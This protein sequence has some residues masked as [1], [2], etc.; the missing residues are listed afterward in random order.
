MI[1]L[2]LTRLNHSITRLHIHRLAKGVQK[3]P[4]HNIQLA[5]T[6]SEV[7]L[8]YRHRTVEKSSTFDHVPYHTTSRLH[9]ICF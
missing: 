8:Q 7:I 9:N 3:N 2:C 1:A 5:N 4:A 6:A